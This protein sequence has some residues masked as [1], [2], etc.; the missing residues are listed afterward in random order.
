M[1]PYLIPI[2]VVYFGG[3]QLLPGKTETCCHRRCG[4]CIT[5]SAQCR[6]HP[7]RTR[8]QGFN[9]KGRLNLTFLMLLKWILIRFNLTNWLQSA[10]S[11]LIVYTTCLSQSFL[12][13]GDRIQNT[14][15]E[16]TYW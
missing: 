8:K 7:P 9:F 1:I 6:W 14:N 10:Q 12:V 16:A 3:F 5:E 11:T 4:C 15:A 13:A 2:A